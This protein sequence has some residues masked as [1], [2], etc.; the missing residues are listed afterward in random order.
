M[1]TGI[2]PHVGGPILPPGAP[3]VLIDFLPAATVTTMATCVGPPDMIVM[4]STGVMINFLPAAR[5]G[6]PT[7]HGG[8]IVLGSF[9]CIIG[10]TGSPSPGMGGMG[11]VMAGL[12]MAGSDVLS[13]VAS[14]YSTP[15]SASSSANASPSPLTS[16]PQEKLEI[17]KAFYNQT[18]WSEEKISNHLRGIDFNKPVEVVTLKPGDVVKQWV[19][20]K[21]GIGN[22]FDADAQP[23]ELGLYPASAV[24]REL[25]TFVV[26]KETKV[27]KSTAAGI[28][29]DWL[30]GV[31]PVSVKGGA[32]QCFV[33]PKDNSNFVPGGQKL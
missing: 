5:L 6:D 20:P 12:A 18:G 14:A 28:R 10:E 16:T 29:I 27:L 32:Q 15:G 4:G 31:P 13:A 21:A 9:T 19:D 8:V 11:A 25:K 3:T 2:V 23:E 33:L 22:Y 30:K 17:A 7:V 24:P 1:V 26:S